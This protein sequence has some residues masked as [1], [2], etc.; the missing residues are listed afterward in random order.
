V[1]LDVLA[2]RQMTSHRRDLSMSVSVFFFF[3]VSADA[4][5]CYL[6]PS[7]FNKQS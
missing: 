1:Y 4:A 6:Q 5:S 3:A 7:L 2:G